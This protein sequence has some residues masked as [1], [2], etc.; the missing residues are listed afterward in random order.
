MTNI[1]C[2]SLIRLLLIVTLL[3]PVGGG[4]AMAQEGFADSAIAELKRYI[5]GNDR[6]YNLPPAVDKPEFVGM[7]D[8]GL[9]LDPDEIVFVEEFPGEDSKAVIYPR[10]I[11]VMHEVVNIRETGRN[12]TVTYCPLTGTV[13]GYLSKAGGQDTSFG[14]MGMLA[15]SN[16]ILY[17]RVTNTFW[18][19]LLGIGIRGPLKGER[20]ERFPLI[21]TRWKY[22]KK[23]Y[24]EGKV[25][26]RRT[27]YKYRYGKDRYGSYAKSGT[28]YDTGGSYYAL[29]HV[30]PSIHPKVRI[31]GLA[32][33]EIAVAFL[34]SEIKKRRL[35]S[36]DF[37]MS[38]IV[39]IYD[40]SLDAIR[41]FHAEAD[42]R[43][44]H[45]EMA[46]DEIVDKETRS[47]W[48]IMG[49]ATEGRLRG[50][51]LERVAAMDSMWFAWKAFHP[52]TEV[53]GRQSN[54][55]GSF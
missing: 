23:R 24:P 22:A 42:G 47:R 46:G 51:K 21:W 44:L 31:L 15:N 28:Y 34:E 4:V 11:L 39:A 12:R 16:R 17:D 27:G 2:I 14:N 33:G 43:G 41:V 55:E 5:V 19:Q 52:F 9:Y 7:A 32:E 35:A 6:Q 30:D 48:D 53:W 29:A 20:L 45:F 13:V 3:A 25:L 26:S 54:G 49:Q 8:A 50:M 1:I 40:K 36:V 18:P 38:P 37:G 10:N